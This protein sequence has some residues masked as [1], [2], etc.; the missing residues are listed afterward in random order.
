MQSG[1][2][3]V[4]RYEPEGSRYQIV[5]LSALTA[6]GGDAQTLP[7]ESDADAD[8]DYVE[9]DILRL[10]RSTLPEGVVFAEGQV[11]AVPQL[12]AAATTDTGWSAP[13]LFYADGTASDAVL[14]L[15]NDGGLRLRVTLRG[16]TGI[17]R[18]SDE[19]TP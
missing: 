19:V 16:L 5:L 18:T 17:S 10:S 14:L 6:D 2:T 4:F 1:E 12:A 11:A 7:P 15:A 9:G 3:Y 13:I 8:Q